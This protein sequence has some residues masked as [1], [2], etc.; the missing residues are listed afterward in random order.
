M[1]DNIDMDLDIDFFDEG[2]D[3]GF[4][5]SILAG[6]G[7]SEDELGDENLTGIDNDAATQLDGIVASLEHED[8]PRGGAAAGGAAFAA[9]PDPAPKKKAKATTKKAPVKR[10]KKAPFRGVHRTS[11]TGWGAKYDGERI[12]IGNVGKKTCDTARGA[13]LAYDNHLRSRFPEKYVK[14]RNFSQDGRIFQNSL[15]LPEDEIRAIIKANYLPAVV[16]H[17]T[18][19]LLSTMA[20]Q[21]ERGAHSTQKRPRPSPGEDRAAQDRLRQML[22]EDVAAR[23]AAKASGGLVVP[24]V[25]RQISA[26]TEAAAG[27]FSS[28]LFGG[29]SG[30]ASG[31][32]SGGVS[33]GDAIS[34]NVPAAP[35]TYGIPDAAAITAA[36]LDDDGSGSGPNGRKRQRT[37]YAALE[38]ALVVTGAVA[39]GAMQMAP[40]VWIGG[41]GTALASAMGTTAV[42]MAGLMNQQNLPP[43]SRSFDPSSSSSSSSSEPSFRDSFYIQE[44]PQFFLELLHACG[45]LGRSRNEQYGMISWWSY[46][47]CFI[48]FLCLA[49]VVVLACSYKQRL[50]A[51]LGCRFPWMAWM[52]VGEAYL[53]CE[54]AARAIIAPAVSS[55]MVKRASSPSAGESPADT[56]REPVALVL[57]LALLS[58][59]PLPLLLQHRSFASVGMVQ[60]QS[61]QLPQFD[62]GFD[63]D[64]RFWWAA[65]LMMWF[66]VARLAGLST[67]SSVLCVATMPMLGEL[68]A[69]FMLRA[70]QR[71]KKRE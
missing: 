9:T 34:M 48:A 19:L 45:L 18:K 60:P 4:D 70:A 5:D 58:S 51:Q 65:L 56:W 54:M 32:S 11:D 38:R 52:P 69:Y 36:I 21:I 10:I 29:P 35:P 39:S 1:T 17:E 41:A 66:L 43:G 68:P 57:M 40:D 26:G 71:N 30:G 15:G 53:L 24:P 37:S 55:D 42:G 22:Q 13:A 62:V 16:E 3:G 59:C 46:V 31:G 33:G 6:L 61:Q 23:E 50:A 47:W 2:E 8:G 49:F 67:A 44:P 14:L 25:R 7:N 12:V 20:P 28:M 64:G 63:Y 27:F